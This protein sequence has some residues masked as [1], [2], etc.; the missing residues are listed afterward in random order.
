MGRYANYTLSKITVLNFSKVRTVNFETVA[1]LE[2]LYYSY[3]ILGASNTARP[4]QLIQYTHRSLK[5]RSSLAVIHCVFQRIVMT[6][7]VHRAPITLAPVGDVDL[8]PAAEGPYC[9]VVSHVGDK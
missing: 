4:E 8:L 1:N 6:L 2:R 5:C 9:T 3:S 7:S